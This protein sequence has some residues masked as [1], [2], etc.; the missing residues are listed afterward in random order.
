MMTGDRD[1]GGSDQAIHIAFVDDLRLV[2]AL[3]RGEEAAFTVLVDRYH[4]TMVRLAMLHVADSAVAEEVTQEAWLGVLQ[5]LRRFEARSSLKTWIFRI[6]INC[7]KTRGQHESR[8][9]P[10]SSLSPTYQYQDDVDPAVAPDRFGQDAMWSSEPHSWNALPEQT[11]LSNE[12]QAR[13]RV[14]I[15][16]LP[17]VQ[18]EVITLRDIEGWPAVEVCSSLGISEANQRV[19]LHRARSKVRSALEQ[20]FDEAVSVAR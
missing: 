19:L 16:A 2:E 18:Q 4:G 9:S 10:F 13:T 14:A 15:A 1:S 11:F 6:L 7:A 8:S 12:T 17:P 3:R 20:Y 5:G